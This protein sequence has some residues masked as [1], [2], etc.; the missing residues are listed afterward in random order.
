LKA[1]CSTCPPIWLRRVHWF[2]DDGWC[3][4]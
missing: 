1:S 4:S 3:Q 2:F